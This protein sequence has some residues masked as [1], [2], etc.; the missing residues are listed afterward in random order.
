MARAHLREVWRK[1]M[2][3]SVGLDDSGELLSS[4]MAVFGLVGALVFVSGWLHAAGMA[5]WVVLV[6][7]PVA[8]HLVGGLR[9]GS[10]VEWGMVDAKA[11][12]PRPDGRPGTVVRHVYPFED[13]SSAHR[14]I[15]ERLSIGKVLPQP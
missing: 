7:L 13:A 9:P 6:F 14:L 4:R 2:R 15:E 12:Q 8:L 10:C 3:P 1:A 11:L 5:F